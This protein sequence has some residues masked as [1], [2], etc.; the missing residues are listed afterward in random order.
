M[1]QDAKLTE[2]HMFVLDVE[3][4]EVRILETFDWS[5]PVYVWIVEVDQHGDKIREMMSEHS[6][7]E[8]EPVGGNA[9]FLHP[10]IASSRA[11]RKQQCAQMK[12]GNDCTG[13]H[14]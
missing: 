10:D 7:V 4:A 5:V 14:C 6:Y 8:V 11:E 1:I 12:A 2:I 9:V 3:G 13:H